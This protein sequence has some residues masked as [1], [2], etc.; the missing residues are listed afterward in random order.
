M[1]NGSGTA[2]MLSQQVSVRTP[3]TITGNQKKAYTIPMQNRH[4]GRVLDPSHSQYCEGIF[5]PNIANTHH[6]KIISP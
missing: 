5:N 4:K 2:N 6:S 3:V 1:R